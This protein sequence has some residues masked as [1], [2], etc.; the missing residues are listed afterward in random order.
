MPQTC[1]GLLKRSLLEDVLQEKK[2]KKKQAYCQKH[3]NF[4]ET[5][6]LWLL[7]TVPLPSPHQLLPCSPRIRAAVG[8]GCLPTLLCT[9][10]TVRV[11]RATS[12]KR[13][14]GHGFQEF[15]E[16]KEAAIFFLLGS[17]GCLLN[18]HSGQP[19]EK[20]RV[21]NKMGLSSVDRCGSLIIYSWSSGDHR[22]SPCG[23]M[24]KGHLPAHR[25]PTPPPQ[26]LPASL[27]RRASSSQFTQACPDLPSPPSSA[28]SL[29]S[30]SEHRLS[31]SLLPSPYLSICTA[32][33]GCPREIAP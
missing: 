23:K 14:L 29:G 1:L 27:Q 19:L 13:T 21:R 8:T 17:R 24:R 7:Q 6:D 2:K 32:A 5:K 10:A 15:H 25:T 20:P 33:V 3:L 30:G 16:R 22:L 4:L 11:R 18:I 28:P 31:I 12:W 26:A 9:W